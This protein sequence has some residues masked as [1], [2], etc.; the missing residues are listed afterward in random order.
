MTYSTI[1][2]QLSFKGVHT[3]MYNT[4]G[5]ATSEHIF[6]SNESTFG[7]RKNTGIYQICSRCFPSNIIACVYLRINRL[8]RP[9]F[10]L[11]SA[12]NAFLFNVQPCRNIYEQP[13]TNELLKPDHSEVGQVPLCIA[14]YRIVTYQCIFLYKYNVIQVSSV[15]WEHC[16]ACDL[17]IL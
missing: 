15:S 9:K 1:Y 11:T 4:L 6:I 8:Q 5:L 10:G 7:E 17:L 16:V 3:H 12:C 14:E 13:R 2:D